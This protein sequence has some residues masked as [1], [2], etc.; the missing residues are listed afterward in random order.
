MSKF[1][2]KNRYEN[3]PNEQFDHRR[4]HH[5]PLF[6]EERSKASFFQSVKHTS[7]IF[8]LISLLKLF[9]FLMVNYMHGV[10]I[11]R[12]IRLNAYNFNEFFV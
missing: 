11:T 6:G 5:E 3:V 2:S 7:Y 9:R 12:V 8:L 1:F 4:A 10:I